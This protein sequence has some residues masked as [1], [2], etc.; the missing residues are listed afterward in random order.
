MGFEDEEHLK[1]RIEH[2]SYWLNK[3]AP[4]MLKF[5]LKKNILNKNLLPEQKK[6]ISSLTIALYSQ[7]WNA[8]NIHN[9]IYDVAEKEKIRIKIAFKAI[10][11]ILLGQEMGPRAGYFLSNLNRD[12]VL[13]QFE[14]VVK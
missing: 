11:Q 6:F 10:Y 2:V 7:A 12:F 5:K 8:E 13:K 3:F 1:Q 14:E 4:D 9:V